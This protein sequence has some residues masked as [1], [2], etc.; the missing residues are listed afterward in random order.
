MVGWRCTRCGKRHLRN[1]DSCR[2]CGGTI[3]QQAR[4]TS[5]RFAALAFGAGVGTVVA[6]WFVGVL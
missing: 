5:S 2:R 3:L 1:P 4:R 6:L